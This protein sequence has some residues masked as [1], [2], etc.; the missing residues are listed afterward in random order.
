M[1]NTYRAVLTTP[2]PKEGEIRTT[3]GVQFFG[4]QGDV[5]ISAA[6]WLQS[7]GVEGD[8]F[9]VSETRSVVVTV[10]TCDK[11]FVDGLTIERMEGK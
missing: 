1:S 4:P 11:R 6:S 5:E 9:E 8:A 7:Q 3:K 2:H 10:L